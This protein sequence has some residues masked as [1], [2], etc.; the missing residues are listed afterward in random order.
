MTEDEL[1]PLAEKLELAARSLE[2]IR[3]RPQGRSRTG[4]DCL[5]LT[6]LVAQ[7]A[8]LAIDVPALPLR[9]FDLARGRSWLADL[10]CRERTAAQSGDLLLQS[11]ASLQLHLAVK[12]GGGV[13][14]AHAGLRRVV[15]RP[16]MAGETWDSAWRLP[17]GDR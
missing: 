12:V 14:E 13:V 9:G 10:G 2:G 1:H 3:F 5:G 8:G 15:F 11:P 7:D 16:L 4:C 6:I 17:L